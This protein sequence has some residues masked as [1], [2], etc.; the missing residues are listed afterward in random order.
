[1]TRCRLRQAVCFGAGA[2]QLLRHALF[3]LILAVIPYRY[4]AAYLQPRLIM[5]A[6]IDLAVVQLS[7]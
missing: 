1:M 3:A 6:T 7:P 4:A 2:T 5:A